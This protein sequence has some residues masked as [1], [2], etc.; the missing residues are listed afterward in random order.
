MKD[1]KFNLNITL[2]R[3]FSDLE[4]IKVGGSI[5]QHIVSF[6]E[7]HLQIQSCYS[8]VEKFSNY[9]LISFPGV[10]YGTDDENMEERII[11]TA[12]ALLWEMQQNIESIQVSFDDEDKKELCDDYRRF[13][14]I[15]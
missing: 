9:D 8:D 10:S 11:F 7:K 3:E 4:R 1:S 15:F 14:E 2:D 12:P 13:L 6:S 5:T